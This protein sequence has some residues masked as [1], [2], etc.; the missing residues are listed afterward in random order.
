M[1]RI[2]VCLVL[3]SG[4]APCAES[5]APSTDVDYCADFAQAAETRM[6]DLGCE[7]MGWHATCPE[8]TYGL[9]LTRGGTLAIQD[10]Q[11]CR[12][13]HSVLVT[14]DGRGIGN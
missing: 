13:L 7:G 5:P 12:Q 1:R 14:I 4:C 11:D 8:D 3:L 10:A 9:P 6:R 2:I